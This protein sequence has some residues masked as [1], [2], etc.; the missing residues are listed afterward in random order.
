MWKEHALLITVEMN[1][2]YYQ[3]YDGFIEHI[4][5]TFNL[6]ATKYKIKIIGKFLK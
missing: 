1:E 4:F 6:H 5:T 2:G 3:E